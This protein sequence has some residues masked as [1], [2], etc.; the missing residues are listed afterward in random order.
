MNA[1]DVPA[2]SQT[3]LVD[4]DA[5]RVWKTADGRLAAAALVTP[6][7]GHGFIEGYAA[8]W[9]T[10]DLQ[11]EIIRR[12][13]FSQS[14]RERVPAGKVKL[15]VRHF[16]HGGDVPE[17]IGTVTEMREDDHG[18]SFHADF[19]GTPLA[20]QT[21]QL[22]TEGHVDGCSIG[23]LPLRWHWTRINGR[24]VLEHTE[25][26]AVEVTVTAQPANEQA[27]ITRAKA[28]ASRER[29]LGRPQCARA[30][31]MKREIAACHL[32]LLRLHI[33]TDGD[34]VGGPV[35]AAG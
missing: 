14:I 29:P 11:N 23:F 21:R 34:A 25:C 19:A 3:V 7:A 15:M 12:G 9:D 24:P 17:L 33:P 35:D 5:R 18:L 16:A 20:Q 13:A 4:R 27:R 31:Q 2:A 32:R 8:I 1:L 30:K 26:K 22:V 10:V 28:A 6:A